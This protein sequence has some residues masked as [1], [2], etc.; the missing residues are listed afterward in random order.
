MSLCD[1]AIATL[2]QAA[3]VLDLLAKMLIVGRFSQY[4]YSDSL[5]AV[6]VGTLDEIIECIVDTPLNEIMEY[7]EQY[8]KQFSDAYL[9]QRESS[10][11]EEEEQ[12]HWEQSDHEDD[13]PTA[14][15]HGLEPRTPLEGHRSLPPQDFP[16]PP[17]PQ[18]SIHE[19]SPE[20]SATYN[21]R[22]GLI[23]QEPEEVELGKMPQGNPT[24]DTPDFPHEVK[25]SPG[26]PGTHTTPEALIPEGP[27]ESTP[28]NMPQDNFAPEM[29]DIAQADHPAKTLESDTVPQGSLDDL[30]R[31][32]PTKEVLE[33]R[34]AQ[35]TPMARSA[36]ETTLKVR[37][38][39][40]DTAE[41]RPR[42]TWLAPSP[43]TEQEV[44]EML[45]WFEGW[46]RRQ[47]RRFQTRQ[48]PSET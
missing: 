35:S 8:W 34:T 7:M 29:P 17:S 19:K 3:L 45:E 37:T 47:R 36:S 22:E 23:S 30:A 24:P 32:L 4:A 21:A 41:S 25:M 20:D 13:G 44:D 6:V 31:V 40:A 42:P 5:E 11:S 46:Q 18:D 16:L 12:R 2:L 1:E 27:H 15:S 33:T 10:S 43:R 26:D 38:S 28:G 48:G 39:S 14:S 9:L